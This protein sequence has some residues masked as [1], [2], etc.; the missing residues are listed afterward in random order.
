MSIL[1]FG[2]HLFLHHPLLMSIKTE[3]GTTK[4]CRT[5]EQLTY[6][7]TINLHLRESK[8]PVY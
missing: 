3:R 1:A 6:T 4:D 7:H 8:P 5:K 2:T